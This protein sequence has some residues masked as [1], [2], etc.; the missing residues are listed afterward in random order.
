M[1]FRQWFGQVRHASVTCWSAWQLAGQRSLG[2]VAAGVAFYA[3]LA[4]FPAL[5]AVIAVWGMFADPQV[6][7]DQLAEL[8]DFLPAP[9]FDV[10]SAQ[11]Q[12]LIGAQA[13]RAG[14]TMAI[15]LGAVLW[16]A[17]AGVAALLRGV[18][19]ITGTRLRSGIHHQLVALALTITLV[20][21]A[22]V[23][24]VAG[25]VVPVI[26]AFVP[27]GW[28][29]GLVIRM[30]GWLIPALA[31]LLGIGLIYR[32]GTP[33]AAERPGLLSP[34]LVVAMAL[35]LVI[36]AGFG[37]YLANLANYNRIYGSIGAVVALLMWLYLG[38]WAVLMGAAVNTAVRHP[39][40]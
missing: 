15:G 31:V 35:W 6:V 16:S 30:A 20:G 39:N 37:W 40:A 24:L 7:A 38:A 34:G 17:R 32:F 26:M 36:S 10:V 33:A 19:V 28:F 4:V 2:L 27:V 29:T 1:V 9:V 14:W 5:A 13:G 21:V 12:G 23:V 11:I 8:A 22:V 18:N 3:I 25:V